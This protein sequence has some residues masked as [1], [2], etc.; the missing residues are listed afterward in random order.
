MS[1]SA[2]ITFVGRLPSNTRCGTTCLRRALGA[3]LLLGL[4]ERERL[5]LR[6]H[7]R[8]Q[9]VVVVA[10]RV[11]VLGEPDQV[12]R[13]QLRALVDQLVEAVLAV[14]ARLAPVDRARSGSRRGVRRASR[15]CR[16]T[17]S[18]AAG[19]RPGS[20]SGTA[21]RASRRRSGRRR[22]RRTRPRAGPSATGRFCSNGV[23]RKCSSI[24]VEAGQHLPEALGPDREHRRQADRR[25]HRVAAADPVPEAEHV[26]GVDPELRD[27]LGVGRDRDEVLGDRRL[28]AAAPPATSRARSARWSSSRAS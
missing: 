2:R 20:A 8:H 18:S 13:D 14:G 26:V 4:A 9:Q 28:V 25:V 19:G 5:G 27:L 6:E 21:R 23:V 11:Q 3:D 1:C 22:S 16:W 10:E 15:A 12:D 7:V 24:V 17:P